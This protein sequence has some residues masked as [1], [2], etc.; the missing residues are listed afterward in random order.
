MN[1][2]RDNGKVG[3]GVVTCNR[4]GFFRECIAAIPDVDVIVVAND[5]E[6]YPSTVYPS[7]IKEVLQHR[8]NRGVGRSKNHALRTLIKE[9]C[10]HLFL[11][12]DDMRVVNPDL[13]KEYIHAAEGS[14]IL[15][16]NF[17][18]HGPENR[19]PQGEIIPPRKLVLY[20]D[21]VSIALHQN[22]LGAFQYFRID[23]LLACGL[24]DPVYKN[25]WEHIDHTYR[26]IRKGFHPP[27]W[28]FAD[29]ADSSHYIEDMDPKHTSSASK[30]D[31]RSHAFFMDLFDRYFSFKHG[32]RAGMVP[33]VSEV[34]VDRSL[35]EIKRKYAC[36]RGT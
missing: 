17:A 33:D 30:R 7:R 13:C 4:M 8:R 19:S 24:F 28:W 21:D 22:V 36:V 16:F 18:Y 25:M 15:H 26:I 35:A 34:E 14:G 10:T 9:G 27:F 31:R 6:S 20:G 23:V 29:L 2:K 3:I 12:E 11:C 32:Y 1:E 5:G